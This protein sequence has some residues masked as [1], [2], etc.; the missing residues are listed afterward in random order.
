M[1]YSPF[2]TES[3]TALARKIRARETSSVEVVDAHIALLLRQNPELNAV[4][5]VRLAD[6]RLEARAADAR[7]AAEPAAALPPFLGVP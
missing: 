5:E 7:V 3:A 4:V 2:V 1:P 6:A